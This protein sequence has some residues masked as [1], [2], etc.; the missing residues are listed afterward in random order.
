MEE[1]E[2]LQA[3]VEALKLICRLLFV[4]LGGGTGDFVRDRALCCEPLAASR[5]PS[6]AARHLLGAAIHG[7]VDAK[8]A[9]DGTD[10]ASSLRD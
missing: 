9:L 4:Q 6:E 1:V 3:E 2:R 8:S 10:A 7:L 5:M